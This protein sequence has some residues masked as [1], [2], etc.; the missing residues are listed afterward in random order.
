MRVI[1]ELSEFLKAGGHWPILWKAFDSEGQTCLVP[2]T[3]PSMLRC[4]FGKDIGERNRCR[5]F[6]WHR[7]DDYGKDYCFGGLYSEWVW[8]D[9]SDK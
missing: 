2:R 3:W 8:G 6:R 1:G 9:V 7:G 4:R 5:L